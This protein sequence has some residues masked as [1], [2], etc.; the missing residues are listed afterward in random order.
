MC[1]ECNIVVLHVTFVV[2]KI[3]QRILCCF[4]H[5]LINGTIFVKTYRKQNVCFDFLYNFCL[6]HFLYREELKRYPYGHADM[7]KIMVTLRNVAKV[8][9]KEN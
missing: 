2:V 9:K 5:C 7:T 8:P 6:K 3:Q 4:P 1:I